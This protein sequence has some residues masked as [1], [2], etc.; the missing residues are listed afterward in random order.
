[1]A[2]YI[3]VVFVHLSSRLSS[4]QAICLSVLCGKNLVLNI[5]HEMFSQ[6]SLILSMVTG[7]IDLCSIIQLSVDVSSSE[8][9]KVKE[10]K[11]LLRLFSCP[12]HEPISFKI[13]MMI[14]DRYHQTLHFTTDLSYFDFHSRPGEH[15][16]TNTSVPNATQSSKLIAIKSWCPVVTSWS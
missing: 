14:D 16:K 4:Q 8:G 5:I 7:A 12:C 10:K 2:L 6:N 3:S 9:H 11:S 1:M 13:W 15:D